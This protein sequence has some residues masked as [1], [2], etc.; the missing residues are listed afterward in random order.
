[1]IEKK[2]WQGWWRPSQAPSVPLALGARSVGRANVH[3]GWEH[4]T[5]QIHWINVYWGVDG[6]VGFLTNC[7]R[8]VIPGGFLV[9]HPPETRIQGYPTEEAGRYRWMTLDGPSAMD[10]V[11]SFGFSFFHP[12]PV[13]RCPEELFD[14][15]ETEIQDVTATGE[16][17][18]G[19]TA[20]EILTRAAW[21]G[22][23]EPSEG[24]TERIVARCLRLIQDRYTENDFTVDRLARELNIH[25]SSLARMFARSVGLPLSDYIRRLRI[26]RAISL[27]KDSEKTIREI[28]F[29]CGFTDPAYFS[30]CLSTELGENPKK[31]REGL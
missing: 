7:K 3:P 31:I 11:K 8:C 30:R 20:Y 17:R 18:A 28:A 25:R 4:G 1:M 26:R 13:G 21:G 12:R 19:R 5:G 23:P 24:R 10:I 16:Y 6:R 27:L 29:A 15:L 14:Q 9:L 22:L 2:P